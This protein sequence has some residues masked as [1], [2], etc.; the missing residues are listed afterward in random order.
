MR[1]EHCRCAG[2]HFA[3]SVMPVSHQHPDAEWARVKP[4][5]EREYLDKNKSARAVQALLKE[6]YN[7]D[8]TVRKLK[9][10]FEAW[11][12]D[13]KTTARNYAA[14]SRVIEDVGSHVVFNVPKMGGR[15]STRKEASKVQKEFRRKNSN[16]SKRGKP[17]N[18]EVP[19]DLAYQILHEAG[20]TMEHQRAG[21][22]PHL[23]GAGPPPP[24]QN[25]SPYSTVPAS[26]PAPAEGDQSD[27]E[28]DVTD[29]EESG[30][31]PNVIADSSRQLNLE[32]FPPQAR[33]VQHTTERRG[34]AS[35]GPRRMSNAL[36]FESAFVADLH[37]T[38]FPHTAEYRLTGPPAGVP[39]SQASASSSSG[40]SRSSL[41]AA[42]NA[43]DLKDLF[44]TA[45]NL[46]ES[47]QRSAAL[48][49][50]LAAALKE[51]YRHHDHDGQRRKVL[52]FSAYYVGQF[53][54]NET[55]DAYMH[56][57]RQ[58]ARSKLHSML[59]HG[60]TQLLPHCYWLSSVVMSYDKSRQLLAFIEDCIDCI[61]TSQSEL[62]HLLRPWI[63]FIIVM[64]R[65]SYEKNVSE[66][67]RL[68][69]AAVDQLARTF[70][71]THELDES[72]R[73]LYE[74]QQGD[75]H[76]CLILRV[77][78]AWY[79][80]HCGQANKSLQELL[81]CMP[82]A[83]KL[84]GR[85]HLVSINCNAMAA[86]AYEK[87]ENEGMAENYIQTALY[88]LKPC[89]RF[90]LSIYNKLLLRLAR[91][92]KSQS[93]LSEARDNLER[94][95]EFRLRHFGVQAYQT[96]EAHYILFDIMVQQGFFIEAQQRD[97]ELRAHYGAD[98][99]SRPAAYHSQ[100]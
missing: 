91:Y 58:E 75:S 25:W 45:M 62:A 14:M 100:Q 40:S 71:A 36:P 12:W 2:V 10:K 55:L 66:S 13:K 38:I 86:R 49:K 94:V 37:R 18:P 50:T 47:D 97:A 76:T 41:D 16:L 65:E 81:Y 39:Q 34:S 72:I 90:L 84:F 17:P 31:E 4:I 95:L 24:L 26:A 27:E 46:R 33:T 11:R 43:I 23:M 85:R 79:L 1:V 32:N 15:S 73:H 96:W 64:Y 88:L 52:E 51:H 44:G 29:S 93:K 78:R 77:Y 60:N 89:S 7:F 8:T 74:K 19:L 61:E 42:F 98:W 67:S 68:S 6:H 69:P 5:I 9:L 53:L 22:P 48:E 80:G 59:E 56:V 57:D 3:V 54:A 83:E 35:S 99:E 82:P 87:L 30:D 21:P 63:Y 70:N 20:I 92:Q 28:G